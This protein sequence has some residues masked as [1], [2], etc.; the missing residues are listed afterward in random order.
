M[1]ATDYF[2]GGKKRRENFNT[3]KTAFY[4]TAD[5]PPVQGFFCN[6]DY[7]K[8]YLCGGLFPNCVVLSRESNS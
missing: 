2:G 3:N 7:F 1:K 6:G 5:L 4:N 8:N